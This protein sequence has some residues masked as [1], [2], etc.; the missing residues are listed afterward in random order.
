MADYQVQKNEGKTNLIINYLPQ[1]MTEKE[2]YSMFVTIGPV[3]S[4]RVMKD[5]KVCPYCGTTVKKNKILIYIYVYT[6]IYVYI[7]CN[8]ILFVLCCPSLFSRLGTA[9]D[10][11]LLITP[12]QKMHH[13]LLAH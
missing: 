6:Y 11:A 2:L 10:L 5:F 1:N 13:E 4:C 3:E 9:M 12:R 8:C 7:S